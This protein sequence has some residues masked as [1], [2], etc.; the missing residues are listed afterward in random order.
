MEVLQK[1]NTFMR[2]TSWDLSGHVHMCSLAVVE[3]E[4]A[5]ILERIAIFLLTSIQGE[6]IIPSRPFGYDEL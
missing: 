4:W 3:V 6:G 2:H 5:L 1:A